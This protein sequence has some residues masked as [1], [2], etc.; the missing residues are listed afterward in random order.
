MGILRVDHPDIEEFIRMKIDGKSVN[1]F[2]ISVAATDVFMD[3]VK[4]GGSYEIT[5]PY[6]KKVVASKKAR[7]IFDLIVESAWAVGDPGLIFID[8]IN[9]RNPP[10]V[11]APSAPP[12]PAASSRFTSTS[13]ATWALSISATF[14]VP[15]PRTSL[16]GSASAGRSPWPCASS[17]T[18]SRSTST[19][20]P[21]SP[22]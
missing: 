12:T 19:R 15:T 17:T 1:N 14:S 16:T 2:N 9:A 20:S 10:G 4:A 21:R 6:H 7:P 13:P 5:D 22:K 18:L 3:A 11:S 8:R